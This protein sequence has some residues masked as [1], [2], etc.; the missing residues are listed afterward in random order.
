MCLYS[1]FLIVDFVARTFFKVYDFAENV[2]SIINIELVK[3]A[4]MQHLK[5]LSIFCIKQFI[6][7]L[8]YKPYNDNLEESS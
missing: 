2:S 5:S 6:K 7:L 1:D 3:N 8:R 4:Q